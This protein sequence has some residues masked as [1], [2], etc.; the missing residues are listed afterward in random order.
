[1]NQKHIK[2][3]PR[4]ERIPLAGRK[5]SGVSAQPMGIR[6]IGIWE[7]RNQ[8]LESWLAYLWSEELQTQG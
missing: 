4:K 1:M 7:S 8:E 2:K 6:N 3:E 5:L